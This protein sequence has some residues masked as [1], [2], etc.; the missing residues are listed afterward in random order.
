M[1]PATTPP[2]PPPLLLP[3]SVVPTLELDG[4]VVLVVLVTPISLVNIV[5]D[6]TIELV[7]DIIV[8]AYVP[9]PMPVVFSTVTVLVEDTIILVVGTVVVDVLASILVVG[10][11]VVEVL[12]SILVID[13]VVVDVLVSILVV[14]TVVV[15]V[16]VS[17]LVI[18]SVVVDVLVS[19]L[20]VGTVVVDVLAPVL[21]AS[22][23]VVRDTIIVLVV[24]NEVTPPVV[25]TVGVLGM[26]SDVVVTLGITELEILLASDATMDDNDNMIVGV[27]VLRI[28]EVTDV[29]VLDVC[30]IVVLLVI[31]IVVVTDS[32]AVKLNAEVEVV[33]EESMTDD[34]IITMVE[35]DSTVVA[36]R[37]V[38]GIEITEQ[39]LVK[40][41]NGE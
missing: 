23:A 36:L 3:L 6:T 9:T 34:D 41:I 30:S 7:E 1:T 25:I 8:A 29:T 18:D 16:L 28:S 32:V 33:L 31:V 4:E 14:G 12:V 20:V 35:V 38:V 40:F 13:S 24:V 11:V 27:V 2:A 15:E 17:I 26:I 19:I 37:V 22:S 5:V 21:T 39:S 10:T